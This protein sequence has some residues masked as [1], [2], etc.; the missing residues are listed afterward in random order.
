MTSTVNHRCGIPRHAPLALSVVLTLV[1]CGQQPGDAGPVQLQGAVLIVLDTVRADHLSAYGHF[2]K[3][4]PNID[5]LADEGVL[6]EQVVAYAPWTL[7]SA[8][9]LLSGEYPERVF[10]NRLQRSLVSRFRDAGITTAAVTEGGWMSRAFGIDLGF[11]HYEEEEGE[12]QFLEPGEERNPNPAGGV[13]HTFAR[14]GDWLSRVGDRR[15]FLMIH[16]YEPHAPY[17]RKTFTEGMDSGPVGDRLSID[18]LAHLKSGRVVLDEVGQ[19][20]VDALYD[21]GIHE[22]DRHVGELLTLLDRLGLGD[23]TVVVVTSDHGEELG[24]HFPTETAD[25]GHSLRDPLLLVPLVLR[26]PLNDYPRR[27]VAS[28]VRLLDV[29]PT[30]A[31][32]LDVPVEGA[33]DGS[34]LLPLMNGADDRER[35]ARVGVTKRG[36]PRSG[37][38][39]TGYKYIVA[40]GPD[41]ELPPLTPPPPARQLYDLSEDPGEHRNLAD[42]RPEL[43]EE[44]QRLLDTNAP[45]RNL[46]APQH[47]ESIDPETLERLRSL[48]YVD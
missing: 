5:R 39:A 26:D 10:Q 48:G 43:A 13:D 29:M 47:P 32:L 27:R 34:S 6:F 9:A 14:A 37:I 45:S 21:G 24:D 30:I 4:S 15:F 19:R 44:L 23:R 35:V 16:T 41:R 7:P 33:L 12:V 3:T 25:H 38:R 2:R 46:E 1:G 22:A 20:Y 31:D 28:Q 36:P 40:H 18:F 42:S 11:E 17:T 8:A